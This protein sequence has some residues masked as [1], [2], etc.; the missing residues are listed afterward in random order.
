MDV[1]ITDMC[2][3]LFA[4]H[5]AWK[6][7]VKS[8]L[9]SQQ[10]DRDNLPSQ[11][12]T[13]SGCWV[14]II[15]FHL[16]FRL[17]CHKHYTLLPAYKRLTFSI[18]R[19]SFPTGH[20]GSWFVYNSTYKFESFFL[21]IVI[22]KHAVNMHSNIRSSYAGKKGALWCGASWEYADEGDSS[23]LL[24]SLLFAHVWLFPFMHLHTGV[25]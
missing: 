17:C 14:S 6:Y 3:F 2:L 4:H 22:H 19:L 15:Y 5:E 20:S 11:T 9:F 10:A 1:H 18:A 13:N 24:H 23:A 25:A 7:S 21:S 12:Q 8:H 16:C